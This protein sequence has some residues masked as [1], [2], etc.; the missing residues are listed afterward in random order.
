MNVSMRKSNKISVVVSWNYSKPQTDRKDTRMTN[1][2]YFIWLCALLL[3]CVCVFLWLCVLRILCYFG[4][5]TLNCVARCIQ[6]ARWK[7][8]NEI[9]SVLLAYLCNELPSDGITK[10]SRIAQITKYIFLIMNQMRQNF[11]HSFCFH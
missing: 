7:Y 10:P 4:S 9:M 2:L 5:H 6:L 3:L 11:V 1:K 8:M